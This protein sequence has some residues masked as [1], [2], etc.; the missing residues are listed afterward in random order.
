MCPQTWSNRGVEGQG[1]ARGP[2]R[3]R[4]SRAVTRDLR[5]VRDQGE[6]SLINKF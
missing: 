3:T 1:M 2:S 5:D 4:D 6:V